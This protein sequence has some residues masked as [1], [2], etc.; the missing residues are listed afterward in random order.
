M[1]ISIKD[2]N[3]WPILLF[4]ATRIPCHIWRKRTKLHGEFFRVLSFICPS[5]VF[6]VSCYRLSFSSSSTSTSSL[7][8]NSHFPPNHGLPQDLRSALLFFSPWDTPCTYT[9]LEKCRQLHPCTHKHQFLCLIPLSSITTSFIDGPCPL[10]WAPPPSPAPKSNITKKRMAI[11]PPGFYQ[12]IERGVKECGVAD[13]D[14]RRTIKFHLHPFTIQNVCHNTEREREKKLK[15]H[16][17]FSTF[18]FCLTAHC[19]PLIS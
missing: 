18:L 3:E 12:K 13:M 15:A 6:P 10:R 5:L 7:S 14:E 8:P 4:G 19:C 11:L 1:C 17:S 2:I 16:L 9:P